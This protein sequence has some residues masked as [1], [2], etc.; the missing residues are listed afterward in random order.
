MRSPFRRLAAIAG[1]TA[2]FLAPAGLAQ[3]V[4]PVDFPP[5]TFVVDQ[6]G[7]LGSRTGEVEDAVRELQQSEGLNVYIV[8]VDEFT[9]PADRQQ[10]LNATSGLNSMGSVDS[11]LAVA[12][13]SRQYVFESAQDN[14][15]EPY[16]QN[17]AR[18][19][20]PALG[21]GEWA[22]AA[23]DHGGRRQGRCHGRR[24]VGHVRWRRGLAGPGAA[25]RRCGGGGRRRGPAVHPGQAEEGLPP[26]A[27]TGC[28]PRRP[29]D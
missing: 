26:T 9:D 7:V 22:D 18:A 28:R 23:L 16:D 3:A 11:V 8:Y 5:G 2:V 6:A 1:L 27:P 15:V 29:S 12:V 19:I 10:W 14:P 21:A 13:D 17:I 20:R 24:R 25:D 4:P